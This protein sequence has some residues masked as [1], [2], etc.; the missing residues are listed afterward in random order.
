MSERRKVE[1]AGGV[2]CFLRAADGEPGE[3]DL[4][5]DKLVPH[6]SVVDA[7]QC[8]TQVV[9]GGPATV[10]VWAGLDLDSAAA[11]AASFRI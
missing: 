3:Q 10:M 4:T 8:V 5:C 9:G 11:A 7:V 1:D 6:R 2:E